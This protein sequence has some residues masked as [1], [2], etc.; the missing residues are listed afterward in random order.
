MGK[1]RYDT[2]KESVEQAKKDPSIKKSTNADGT[3]YIDEK[4][5][6]SLVEAKNGDYIMINNDGGWLRVTPDGSVS[7]VSGSGD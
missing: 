6:V 2:Y 5:G 4:N 3:V 7:T 1:K